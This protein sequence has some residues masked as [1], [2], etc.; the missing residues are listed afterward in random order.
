MRPLGGPEM[1]CHC[2][3]VQTGSGL[4]LVDTGI[5]VGAFLGFTMMTGAALDVSETMP[6]RLR[7]LGYDLDDVRDIVLTHLDVDHA[8][9][10]RYFPRARVHL[11][12]AELEVALRP[13]TAGERR[14][15]RTVQWEHG[16]SWVTYGEAGEPW[17][18]LEARP[19][20]GVDGVA[21]VP[22]AGHSRGHSG[23]AVRDG[24]G[25]LLHAGDAY[26][27]RGELASPPQCPPHLRLAQWSV[28]TDHRS[29]LANVRRLSEL[30]PGVRVFSAHD[31]QELA[32]F[33]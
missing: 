12:A 14:R 16:P 29:R 7:V 2:L 30:P 28:A 31:A 3:I 11:H 25:W 21:L 27:A 22:L 24:D 6:A 13:Q 20:D 19:L 32:A 15:Y 8:G 9:A 23:V 5:G 4:T 1:V 17:L 18:G 26:Y 10:L 33:A